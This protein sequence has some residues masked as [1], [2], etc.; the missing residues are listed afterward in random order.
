MASD[1]GP[2]RI[3]LAA[4]GS[5]AAINLP[6]YV[7]AL[8]PL[9]RPLR[10]VLT[11]SAQQFITLRSVE[12]LADEAIDG[13]AQPWPG[14]GPIDLLNGVS[15]VAVAPA[16]VQLLAS[17]AHGLTDTPLVAALLAARCPVV[18]SPNADIDL[19]QSPSVQ[20]NVAQV[21]RDGF[22]VIG[23]NLGSMYSVGRA[24]LV[25]GA[26]AATPLELRTVVSSILESED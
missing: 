2:G 11:R 7:M 24:E 20:R 25:V 23:P 12:L 16:T 14:R 13:G 3:L 21:Q 6:A 8:R 17:L 10:V 18:L 22:R 9:N 1:H 19:W 5:I 26:N 4:C 15:I